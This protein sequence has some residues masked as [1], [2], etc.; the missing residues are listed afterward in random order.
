[1]SMTNREVNIY[2]A[3]KRL[4]QL[5]YAIAKK[6]KRE[7][8]GEKRKTINAV[9]VTVPPGDTVESEELIYPEASSEQDRRRQISS[10]RLRWANM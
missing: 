8:I 2:F 1:M 3:L 10:V 6:E 5:I 7:T 4:P 9:V